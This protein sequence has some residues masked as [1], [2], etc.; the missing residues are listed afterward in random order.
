MT[1]LIDN[2]LSIDPYRNNVAIWSNIQPNLKLDVNDLFH[3]WKAFELK[4]VQYEG[5]KQLVRQIFGASSRCFFFVR[6]EDILFPYDSL[7]DIFA[8]ELE[9]SSDYWGPPNLY[10]PILRKILCI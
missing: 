10:P 6:K 9:R 4:L 7:D 1:H 2:I 3:G 5:I 8:L